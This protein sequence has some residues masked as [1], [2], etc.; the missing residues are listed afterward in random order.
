MPDP[1]ASGRSPMK[2]DWRTKTTASRVTV[3]STRILKQRDTVDELESVNR[4][5][6]LAEKKRTLARMDVEAKPSIRP[7][8]LLQFSIFGTVCSIVGLIV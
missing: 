4:R 1:E 3:P 8:D 7:S 2:T 5:L 6:E